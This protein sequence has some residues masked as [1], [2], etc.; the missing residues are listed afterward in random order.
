MFTSSRI[1]RDRDAKHSPPQL[2]L[3]PALSLSDIV[4]RILG[5]AAPPLMPGENEAQYASLAARIVAGA[6]PRDAIEELLARDVL[7]LTWEILR[8]RRVKTG[9]LKASMHEG[10][11]RVMDDLGYD[12]T[13]ESSK[14]WA[15]G[16]KRA[17]EQVT[18]ALAKANLSMDEVAGVL[19]A[20]GV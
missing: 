9:V 15:A 1:A 8:L 12:E 20:S 16:D 14:A 3:V 4:E 13:Y 5:V 17:K 7:D 10:V 2:S 6:R 19:G 18:R 11:E